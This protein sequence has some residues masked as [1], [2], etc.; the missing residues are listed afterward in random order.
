MKS[1]LK[2]I[3]MF[4]VFVGAGLCLT[5]SPVPSLAQGTGFKVTESQ[6]NEPATGGVRI[7]R[8]EFVTGN[9]TWRPDSNANWQPLRRLASLKPGSQVWAEG[10]GKAEIKFDDGGAV[11]LGRGAIATLD[12]L[13]ADA[14]GPYTRISITTGVGMLSLKS[15]HSVYEVVLPALTAIASGPSR[16]RVSAVRGSEVAVHSGKAVVQRKQENAQKISLSS[17]QAAS[18]SGTDTAIAINK[19]SQPDAWDRWNDE[20]DLIIAPRLSPSPSVIIEGIIL[21]GHRHHRHD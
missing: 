6:T 19:I 13:Y 11:R 21:D 17:G 4:K 5:L 7:A 10:E 16:I 8:I 15:T 20:R 18:I 1:S 9:V 2:P 3:T 12:A 14:Q